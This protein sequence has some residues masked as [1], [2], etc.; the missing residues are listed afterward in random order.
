[1]P[2]ILDQL[3]QQ[4]IDPRTQGLLAAGFQGLQSSGP[5][6][7]PVSLG[8]V[9]GQAGMRG[10]NTMN[11]AFGQ[12]SRLALGREQI[13]AMKAQREQQAALLKEQVEQKQ[14]VAGIQ[15]RIS[16]KMS[17]L[18]GQPQEVVQSSILPELFELNP[19]EATKMLDGLQQRVADR[20]EKI[21]QFNLT[22]EDKKTSREQA[23]ALRREVMGMT[24]SNQAATRA[25]QASQLE[26]ARMNAETQR[27]RAETERAAA[28]AKSDLLAKGKPVP[29]TLAKEIEKKSGVVSNTERFVNTFKDSFGG[30]PFKTGEVSNWMGRTFGDDTGQSQFWQDYQLHRSE[31]RNQLFGSAL[32]AT[33]TAEWE[34][35]DINP[36]MDPKQIK[37]NLKRRADIEKAGLDRWMKGSLASGYSKESIEG[38]AGRPISGSAP[39]TDS[40]V[41]KQWSD[42][43]FDYRQLKNGDIQRKPK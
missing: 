31:V 19:M 36:G 7:M 28:Q 34:K 14:R 37:A 20:E 18:Q 43:K 17:G 38:Y 35:A 27:M 9:I 32:T 21:R 4:Q 29:P 23:E 22:I 16:Q 2:G 1:M 3:D 6:K 39:S 25:M 10:L 15:Q 11:D 13:E 12:Q 33:E 30:M 40:D 41:V 42:D 26:I 8:Q 24:A 5:S